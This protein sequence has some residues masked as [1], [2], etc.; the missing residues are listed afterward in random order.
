MQSHQTNRRRLARVHLDQAFRAR[1]GAAA[2]EVV[3]I[4]LQGAR[5]A[6]SA[7]LENGREC[8][9]HFEYRGIAVDMKCRIL[10]CRF[11]RTT[12]E[13]P[14]YVSGLIFIDAPLESVAALRQV[15][16]DAVLNVRSQSKDTKK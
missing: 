11:E 3:D 12:P 16:A 4:S 9:L 14:M 15:I 6:H 10:R 2:A 5:V 13:R 8:A 1:I 7:P